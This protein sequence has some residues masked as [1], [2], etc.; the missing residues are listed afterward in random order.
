MNSQQNYVMTS[1]WQ[2]F[3]CAT[4]VVGGVHLMGYSW[5]QGLGVLVALIGVTAGR[6]FVRS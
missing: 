3:A 6:A 5:T 2:V 1:L 4:C